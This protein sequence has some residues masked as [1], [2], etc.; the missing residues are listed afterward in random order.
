MEDDNEILQDFL[1]EAGEILDKLGEQLVELEARPDDMDLLNAVF[2]GFHTVKGGAGFLNIT[3]LVELCH[4]AE[5][6]FNVLRQG[7]RK[8]DAE[9]MDVMLRVLD[10]VKAMMDAVRAGRDPEHAGAALLT[11]LDGFAKPDAPPGANKAVPA[12]PE[13][14]AV[15]DTVYQ[16]LLD[17]L[18]PAPASGVNATADAGKPKTTSPHKGDEITDSE[19][20]ALLD[21][22]QTKPKA[23]EPQQSPPLIKPQPAKADEISDAEFDALLDEL[24]GTAG[25]KTTAPPAPAAAQEKPK[26]AA[27]AKTEAQDHATAETSVRVDTKRLD[28]IMNMVGELVLSRNR[29]VRLQSG[30]SNEEVT[31]AVATLDL[32]TSDLQTAVMK[33]RMQP[34]K[35]VFGRFPRVVRDISRSMKK[36][37]TL[38][39]Q[40]EDTDLDKN[41]VEALAD[42]LVHLVRNAVDHGVETPE[43]RAAAG[44]AR[45]GTVILAAEQEGDHILLIIAD[46]GAGMDAE[47][48]RRKVVEKG[49][50]DAEAA[51]RLTQRD[52]YNLVFLP[53]FSTKSEITDISGRGVG[54]DVVKT[55]I[56]QLNGTVEIE[57]QKGKGTR[58]MIKVPLTLAIIP[59][60][61]VMV[62]ARTFALPLMNVH[63]IFDLD[64]S[65]TNTLDG[66]PTIM[67]RDHAL[68]LYYLNHWL[69]RDAPA[70]KA[71]GCRHVVVVNFGIQRVGFVV[72]Q[73]LG[74]EEVVIKPLGAALHGTPGLA[75]ATITGDGRIALILDV[76][77]LMKAYARKAA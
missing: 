72:D 33:T 51:A 66:Q 4:R 3:P 26:G 45:S 21:Q 5:D 65:R 19:F 25:R 7:A 77:G 23:A 57:S 8:V 39:L 41:L 35:K 76:P 38:E 36:E 48:L 18:P 46:D 30:L 16:Q 1:V 53:G 22:L 75:G 12:A 59:T 15:S 73:L 56:A 70:S 50:M 17:T 49:L 42:P 43:V 24:H 9:I 54:L 74:Q 10:I 61:M 60:L 47:V 28:D 68:P 69:L 6:V 44:K 11:Q 58:F 52:C 67:V 13:Q 55:R 20:E 37:V 31:Q 34:I 62:G 63:E 29:L 64:L 27:P 32:V 40:G 14:G 2:R 71:G